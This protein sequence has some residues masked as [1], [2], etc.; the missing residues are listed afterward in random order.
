MFLCFLFLYLMFAAAPRLPVPM[1]IGWHGAGAQRVHDWNARPDDMH[2]E[3]A[4]QPDQGDN[5]QVLDMYMYMYMYLHMY[6]YMYMYM[7]MYMYMYM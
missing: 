4:V 2:C 1:Q 5:A 7:L 3:V 6:M